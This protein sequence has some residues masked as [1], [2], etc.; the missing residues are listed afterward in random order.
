MV[1]CPNTSCDAEL[2]QKIKHKHRHCSKAQHSVKHILGRKL[3]A[4]YGIDL[5]D[6]KSYRVC[7]NIYVALRNYNIP[8]KRKEKDILIIP[9]KQL[10]FSR[11]LNPSKIEI[12]KLNKVTVR[13]GK[14]VYLIEDLITEEENTPSKKVYRS[15]DQVLYD[16]LSK[17]VP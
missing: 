3:N 13:V 7:H 4:Y 10:R 12:K 1:R 11:R 8:R 2:K 14:K 9:T 16:E 15:R 6:D 17:K 5:I